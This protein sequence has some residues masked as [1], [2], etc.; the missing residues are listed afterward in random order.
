M[1]GI[2]VGSRLEQ[3]EELDRRLHVEIELE[4]RTH[5]PKPREKTTRRR[6]PTPRNKVD[7]HLVALGVTT[8]QVKQWALETGRLDRIHR[9]RVSAELVEA[10]AQA[11]Q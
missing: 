6:T 9:G 11:H 7:Q 4:R 2:K 5:P 3:L 10:Y 1:S 8:R